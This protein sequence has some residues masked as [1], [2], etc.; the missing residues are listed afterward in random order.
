[1]G[2][3]KSTAM[4]PLLQTAISTALQENHALELL[5]L[6]AQ[7][8]ANRQPALDMMNRAEEALQ[9]L[10]RKDQRRLRAYFFKLVKLAM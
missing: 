6:A 3:I 5:Q 1:M 4:T 10:P 2:H 7:L 9:P 8:L